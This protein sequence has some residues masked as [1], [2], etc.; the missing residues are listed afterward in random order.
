[1]IRRIMVLVFGIFPFLTNAAELCVAPIENN[2]GTYSIQVGE[3]T[4][5]ID[6]KNSVKIENIKKNNKVV[7]KKNGTAV[8]SFVLRLEK[9]DKKCI[10]Q[11]TLYFTWQV[12]EMRPFCK[13]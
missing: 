12:F 9:N 1:M 10:L 13:C 6:N 7:I 4:Y 3:I 5:N 8:E 2:S 11:N